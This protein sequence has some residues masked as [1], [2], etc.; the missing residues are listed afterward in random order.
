MAAPHRHCQLQ[1]RGLGRA[2][3]YGTGRGLG[4]ALVVNLTRGIEVVRSGR[5]VRVMLAISEERSSPVTLDATTTFVV[6]PAMMPHEVVPPSR[7]LTCAII[8]IAN[9]Q[10]SIVA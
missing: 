4:V 7:C 2:W 10:G 5:A 1:P 6:W 3:I 9:T 8:G